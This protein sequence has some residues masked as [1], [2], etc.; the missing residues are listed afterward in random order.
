MVSREY[1]SSVM[2][3][4]S[5]IPIIYNSYPN[6]KLEKR[7]TCNLLFK[8]VISDVSISKIK[9]FNFRYT[10]VFRPYFGINNY[11]S[12]IFY[13]HTFNGNFINRFK[14]LKQIAS[15]FKEAK[16]L[17]IILSLIYLRINLFINLYIKRK[18]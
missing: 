15:N 6:S 10:D 3:T 8:S 5:R 1:S 14:I 4:Y 13:S 18:Y 17:N 7:D 2:K 11:I 16:T 12:Y 9:T